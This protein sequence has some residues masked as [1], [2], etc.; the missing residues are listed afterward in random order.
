VREGR[1][2]LELQAH[3]KLGQRGL[4]RQQV[5]AS[6]GRL[7]V[8]SADQ[9]HVPHAGEA[10]EEGDHAVA[11]P[12]E[13]RFRPR[14]AL[15][16]LGRRPRPR[17]VVPNELAPSRCVPVKANPHRGLEQLEP[18]VG[19]GAAEQ[20]HVVRSEMP[21][22]EVAGEYET[23]PAR[24]SAIEERNLP[25][26]GGDRQAR[27]PARHGVAE[28]RVGLRALRQGRRLSEGIPTQVLRESHRSAQ[29]VLDLGERRV[30]EDEVGLLLL[31]EHLR[32]QRIQ[33]RRR[34]DDG[35]PVAAR[36]SAHDADAEACHERRQESQRD[37]RA[38]P[39]GRRTGGAGDADR[40]FVPGPPDDRVLPSGNLDHRRLV[41]AFSREVV[42]EL[43][44]KVGD[45]DAHDR[46]VARAGLGRASE[47]RGADLMLPNLGARMAERP[48]A[49][50]DEQIPEPLRPSKA[51]TG[52]DSLL[53]SPELRRS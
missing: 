3:S 1:A 48:L 5:A 49:Q 35:C 15:P 19:A 46:L 16:V 51:R 8:G 2:R 52:G 21:G 29:S 12:Q 30:S 34:L 36:P 22:V 43:L 24:P 25:G 17:R 44:A 37:R 38:C 26:D 9:E 50:V 32:P 33:G 47:D 23:D 53:E 4:V 27:V 20:D 6:A 42:V 39:S 13:V 10:G 7:R 14:F 45:M 40:G 28:D 41:G 18:R 31:S 11:G